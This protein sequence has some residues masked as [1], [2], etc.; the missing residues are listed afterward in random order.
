MAGAVYGNAIAQRL[1][2]MFS[3]IDLG[4]SAVTYARDLIERMNPR[5]PAEEMLIVQ[6]L[7]AHVRVLHLTDLA[8]KQTGLDGVRTVH[9]HADRASNTYRR[10]MLALSEYPKPPR[11]PGSFTAI[12]QANIAQQQVV[13]NQERGSDGNATN[14][15]RCHEPAESEPSIPALGEGSRG[16]PS[17]RL[18]KQA[19]GARKRARDA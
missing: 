13:Q 8:A 17:V 12:G 16:A 14:E 5:D 4:E 7:M 19:V 10:L 3:G 2:Q 18:P 11:T 9:E 1:E 15:Q 6:M